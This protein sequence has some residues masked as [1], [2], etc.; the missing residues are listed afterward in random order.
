MARKKDMNVVFKRLQTGQAIS[1]EA[2]IQT[3][4]KAGFGA[5]RLPQF[6]WMARSQKNADI[7]AA[8]TVKGEGRG[9]PRVTHY[10]L[11]NPEAF[12]YVMPKRDERGRIIAGSGGFKHGEAAGAVLTGTVKAPKAPKVSPEESAQEAAAA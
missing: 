7:V 11:A 2:L 1:K 8:K 5:Y 3:M 9:R 6:L 12:G 10:R 4:E